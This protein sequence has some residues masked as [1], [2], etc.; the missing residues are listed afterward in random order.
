[1]RSIKSGSKAPNQLPRLILH[2]IFH[3]HSVPRSSTPSF[4]LS[5]SSLNIMVRKFRFFVAALAAAVTVTALPLSR[6]VKTVSV[7]ADGNLTVNDVPSDASIA[8]QQ[9]ARAA[10]VDISASVA[11]A[12]SSA[13]AVAATHTQNPLDPIQTP[14]AN[15]LLTPEQL[16][17]LSGLRAKLALDQQFGDTEAAIDDQDGISE[18]LSLNSGEGF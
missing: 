2:S 18:L 14:L 10:G 12:S 5:S 15:Q 4:S 8:A 9:V 17:Q 3:L 13:A 1:M 11:A 16:G 6:R 7:D